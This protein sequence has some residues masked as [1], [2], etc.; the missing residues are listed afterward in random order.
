MNKI[1]SEHTA[2]TPIQSFLESESWAFYRGAS[3]EGNLNC[4]INA[5]YGEGKNKEGGLFSEDALS[6]DILMSMAFIEP[7]FIS[8]LLKQCGW[9]DAK[10]EEYEVAGVQSNFWFPQLTFEDLIHED[11]EDNHL[12]LV[13]PDGWI[14]GKNLLVMIEAKGMR[15]GAAFNYAQLA[16]EYLI[17]KQECPGQPRI[18]LLLT[19]EQIKSIVNKKYS[20]KQGLVALFYKSWDELTATEEVNGK[21]SK[22]KVD[23][24]QKD[25]IKKLLEDYK[26]RTDDEIT[27]CFKML[28]YESLEEY[29]KNYPAENESSEKLAAMIANTIA[30][31]T[32]KEDRV[33]EKK[34]TDKNGNEKTKKITHYKPGSEAPSIW[35][36]MLIDL[37]AEETPLY[38][39]YTGGTINQIVTEA[40][41][42][43]FNGAEIPKDNPIRKAVED[44]RN[45]VDSAYVS[46]LYRLY[47]IQK[48]LELEKENKKI[49]KSA[50]VKFNFE[51][52]EKKYKEYVKN[53]AE[54]DA[55]ICRNKLN[56]IYS[57]LNDNF[58]KKYGESSGI[59]P[60]VTPNVRT[61]IYF[62]IRSLMNNFDD[63]MPGYKFFG[64]D[65][66]KFFTVAM[67]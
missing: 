1:L 27:S 7:A 57:D 22:N 35:S 39:F 49:D 48:Y 28:S 9:G 60:S 54:L 43:F 65:N 59:K 4:C 46:E 24:F 45:K 19:N 16:K 52:F 37:A 38:E 18:L 40:E 55:Q 8:G 67:K 3:K 44:V 14:V 17:A 23:F 10:C 13:Q 51:F 64:F 58:N 11:S 5:D 63:A 36:T 29:A 42:N 33:E 41:D 15:D 47:C 61:L 21:W 62:Y 66:K 25:N 26:P 34:Y 56:R 50:T 53:K 32:P 12:R 6:A 31:H 20:E 2:L 30:W